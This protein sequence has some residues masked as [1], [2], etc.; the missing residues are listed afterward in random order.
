[1]K[2]QEIYQQSSDEEIQGLLRDQKMTT[3]ICVHQE[4]MHIGVFP[5]FYYQGK[6]YLHLSVEDEQIAIIN[7]TKKG[8][9]LFFDFLCHIPSHWISDRDAGFA[10]S[11]YRYLECDCT[12]SVIEDH[13]EICSIFS[14]M[15]KAFQPEGRYESFL[16]HSH[17]YDSSFKELVVLE[18]EILKMKTKWKLGQ[19]RSKEQREKILD[20][21][22]E[23]LSGNDEKAIFE[24]E[25]TMK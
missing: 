3:L 21:L 5:F 7:K 9:L 24:I 16:S 12:I 10:T 8:K 4:E 14:Q 20:H 25:K 23:R 22:R 2:F 15:M 17:F 18:F 19:N 13:N 6:I 11:Y 1:M